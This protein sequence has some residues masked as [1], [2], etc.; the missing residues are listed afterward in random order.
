MLMHILALQMQKNKQAG[1]KRRH[2]T[3]K[4]P[5]F[6]AKGSSDSGQ[7]I[8]SFRLG[9]SGPPGAGKSTFI[10]AFGMMLIEMGHKVAVLPVDPS[11]QISGG[12]ILGDKT[13]MIEL[14][15]HEN[16]FVRPS[17]SR[18]TLGG[19]AQNTMEAIILYF[20][21]TPVRFYLGVKLLDMISF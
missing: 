3:Q 6:Q 9:I 7:D 2:V 17:P 16:A 15:R 8:L 19:V 14:S 5:F 1:L 18:G 13:R 12:S 4:L 21:S 20:L 11:S 10:E